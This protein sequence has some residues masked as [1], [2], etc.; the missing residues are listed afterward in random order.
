MI[1][2]AVRCR[3]EQAEAVLAELIALAPSG[4]EERELTDGRVEY[5]IY[6]AE[7]ELPDLGGVEAHLGEGLVE[8]EA[9]AVPDDWA[10]RWREFHKPVVVGG[11][12]RVRP[13]WCEPDGS[14]ALD[15]VIDPGQ[16]FGTGAHETTRLCLDAMLAYVERAERGKGP[17]RIG[18]FADFGTGSGVL[19][20]AAAKLGFYPVWGYD[21]DPAATAAAR[22]NAA[23]NGVE[24]KIARVDLRVGIPPFAPLTVANLVAPMLIDLAGRLDPE[25]LPGTLICSGIL[26][27]EIDA[28]AEAFAPAGLREAGRATAGTWSALTLVS[29]L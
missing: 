16:A 15:L 14:E 26:N 27:E 20:I 5:A 3:A 12:I 23:A 9:G 10:T 22:E 25:N 7:G 4:V 6:G 24:I 2:L 11:R 18:A 29:G 13:P 1:R 21:H 17:E 19:G 8:V 28:V